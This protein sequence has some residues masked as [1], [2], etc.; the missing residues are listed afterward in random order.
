MLYINLS[1]SRDKA[2]KCLLRLLQF[3]LLCI[4]FAFLVA[5]AVADFVLYRIVWFNRAQ[6]GTYFLRAFVFFYYGLC[7][8][9]VFTSLVVYLRE[10][11]TYQHP[12]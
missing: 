11:F 4:T 7:N 5:L 12:Y 9:I 1:R 6:V 8:S 2:S 3:I 10:V